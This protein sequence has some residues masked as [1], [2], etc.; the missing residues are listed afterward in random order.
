MTML[1]AAALSLLM[2]G[3]ACLSGVFGMAGGLIMIGVLLVVLPLPA[4]MVLHAVTQM[5]SNG[6]RAILWRQHIVWRTTAWYL[7]GCLLAL[8]LWSV[9]LYVPDKGVALLLLGVS[10][11]IVRAISERILPRTLGRAQLVGGGFV[12]QMLMLLSGVT[13]PLVDTLFLRSPMDRKQ[14]IA[15]KAACQ[16]FSHFMK[17]VYFGA[18][19][20][21]A[22]QVE[23]W[24]LALAVASSMLGATLG[25]MLLEKLSEV[26]FRL[27]SNRL[28]NVIACWFIGYSVALLAG[29]A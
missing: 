27:W 4:A 25:K 12:C 17:L 15:T 1:G 2:V 26:Q 13:G 29:V 19:I 3:T 5:A 11:F 24:L 28:I 21:Q 16:V 6:W 23:P 22:G 8:G 14:I 7:A 18:L 10:P 20:E 9:T